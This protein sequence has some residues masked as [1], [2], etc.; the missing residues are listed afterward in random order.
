M[1]CKTRTTRWKRWKNLSFTIVHE[2]KV[3]P[4]NEQGEPTASYKWTGRVWEITGWSSKLQENYPSHIEYTYN[5]L[6]IDEEILK[7]SQY[8]TSSMWKLTN[9]APN[10]PRTPVQF[11]ILK[12]GSQ[13]KEP[14]FYCSKLIRGA[15]S[16]ESGYC[17]LMRRYY[18]RA[19]AWNGVLIIGMIIIE[20]GIITRW[21]NSLS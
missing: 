7:I 1:L 13:H 14:R 16:L 18:R 17:L 6:Q 11:A 15:S 8:V 10:P 3:V 4:Y 21:F 19:R 2:T 5:I 20:V 9:Y 12:I